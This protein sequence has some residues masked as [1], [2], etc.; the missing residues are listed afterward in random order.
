MSVFHRFPADQ[1]AKL[2]GKE[3]ELESCDKMLQERTV[4][5]E[6]MEKTVH[7]M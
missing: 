5:I 2:K 7:G 4:E 6:R 3:S 1:K